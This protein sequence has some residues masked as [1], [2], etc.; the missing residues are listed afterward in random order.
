MRGW[1]LPPGSTW[2][3][4]GGGGEEGGSLMSIRLS[5][6][7]SLFPVQWVAKIEA[8]LAAA[9]LFYFSLFFFGRKILSILGNFFRCKNEEKVSSRTFFSHPAVIPEK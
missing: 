1:V 5:I 8:S 6:K 7:K 3:G 2:W 9:I 4:G